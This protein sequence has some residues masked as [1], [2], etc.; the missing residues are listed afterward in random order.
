MGGVLASF[1]TDRIIPSEFGTTP[2]Y[3]ARQEEPR[4][5]RRCHGGSGAYQYEYRARAA[6]QAHAV[7]CVNRGLRGAV[8]L[9][10]AWCGL[11]GVSGRRSSA[12]SRRSAST[13]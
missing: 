4:D 1:G 8:A 6:G 11:T 5:A 2:C 13:R 7:T 9:G 12:R 10:P 3:S